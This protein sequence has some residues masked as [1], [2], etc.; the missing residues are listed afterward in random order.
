MTAAPGAPAIARSR[1]AV[2]LARLRRQNILF[3]LATLGPI[4]ALFGL[5][6][7]YPIFET[8]RLSFYNYHITQLR[9][10]F[11]GLAELRTP[12]DRRR[13]PHGLA[14]HDRL[15]RDGGLPHARPGARHRRPAPQHRAGGVALRVAVLHPRGDALGSRRGHLEVDSTTPP[16]AR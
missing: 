4:L 5:I 12:A 7:V 6:R 3:V 1:L 15:F 13:V 11:V 10:P 9:R 14:E 8:I 2:T 16:T